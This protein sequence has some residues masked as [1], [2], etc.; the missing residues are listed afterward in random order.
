M[1]AV[2]TLFLVM[3]PLGNVPLCLPVL[4]TVAPERRR[5]VLIREIAFAYTVLLACLFFGNIA[6]QLQEFDWDGYRRR[7]PHLYRLDFILEAEGD[8]T[9]HYPRLPAPLRSLRLFVRY[10]GQ[11]LVVELDR[12]VVRVTAM[13]CQAAAIRRTG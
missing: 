7:Y 5:R 13:H 8:S 1:S 2:V 9:V 3:D 4:K 12:D 10:R 6:L 11:S